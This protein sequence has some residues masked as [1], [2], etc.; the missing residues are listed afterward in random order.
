MSKSNEKKV[1][2]KPMLRKVSLEVKTSV[3]AVCH[4]SLVSSPNSGPASPCHTPVSTC[5]FP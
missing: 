3:L 4:T 1:Y 5:V 2:E